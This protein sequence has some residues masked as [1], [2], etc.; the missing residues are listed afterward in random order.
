MCFLL[1]LCSI[2]SSHFSLPEFCS[3]SIQFS[4]VSWPSLGSLYLFTCICGLEISF[5]QKLGDYRAHLIYFPSLRYYSSV[6]PLVQCLENNYS[7]YFVHF[8]NLLLLL[9]ICFL[10]SVRLSLVVG[11][12]IMVRSGMGI[13]T[14]IIKHSY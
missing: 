8:S 12:S 13:F 11:Y 9:F 5:G 3:L 10:N 2:T 6:L 7:V 4:S 14:F 1:D